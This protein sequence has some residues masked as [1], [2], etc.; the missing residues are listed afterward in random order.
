VDLAVYDVTGRLVRRMILGDL[1]AGTH[2]VN[3]DAG[4]VPSGIYFYRLHAGT[5]LQTRTMVLIR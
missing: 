3:F 4:D 1:A 5:A 2:E